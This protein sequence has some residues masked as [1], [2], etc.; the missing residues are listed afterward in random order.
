[1]AYFE[2][3]LRGQANL[4]LPPPV[5]L[6]PAP[7]YGAP[8][9][10]LGTMAPPAAAPMTMPLPA[11]AAPQAAVA[12]A[13][14]VT[15]GFT[16]GGWRLPQQVQGNPD[17]FGSFLQTQ[18]IQQRTAPTP[19]AAPPPTSPFAPEL[20]PPELPRMLQAQPSQMSRGNQPTSMRARPAT[21]FNASRFPGS[22]RTQ[23]LLALARSR[24]SF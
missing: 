18:G 9:A 12:P 21:R 23:R 22:A 6:A 16:S 7:L 11:P 17:Q 1:M 8:S 5:P 15:D 24:R 14:P 13:P 19:E 4:P 10:A 3:W 2:D 20:A